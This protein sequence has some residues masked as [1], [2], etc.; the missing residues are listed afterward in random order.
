M[1]EAS[2]SS[3]A[4]LDDL[5]RRMQQKT[6]F[7]ALSDAV[8]RIHNV[9]NS[10][11]ES[12]ASLT[13]EI[14]KDVALTNKLLRMVNSAV[15]AQ[16]GRINTVSRAVSLVGFDAIRNLALSLVLLEH[17]QD[18][19]QAGV[20]KEE[21]LRS[22][23]AGSV[24]S[25]LSASHGDAEEAFLGSMF[26]NLGR[27]L[28]E[29]YLP[30]E[31]ARVRE[32]MAGPAG[33]SE[34]AASTQILGLGYETLGL[35]GARAWGLPPSIQQCMKLPVGTPP[36]H[37]PT[38]TGE[39]LRWTAHVANAVAEVLLHAPQS[40][41]N[42]RL[43]LVAQRHARTLDL[44]ETQVADAV[45]RAQHRL[46]DLAKVME[47]D[48]APS[49]PAARLLAA[50]TASEEVSEETQD[51]MMGVLDGQA[52]P[53]SQALSPSVPDS[54]HGAAPDAATLLAAGIQ[55]V[56]LAMVDEM[57]VSDILRM[58]LETLFRALDFQRVVFALRDPKSDALVGRFGLGLA[59]P[60]GVGQ[61]RVPLGESAQGDVFAAVCR[62][63]ADTLI[64]DSADA[65]LRPR[66]PAWFYPAM[67]AGSFLLLP[68]VV[69]GRPVG[70]IY[71]DKALAR[72]IV[73]DD[74]LLAMVRTLRNQAL[75][76][77]RTPTLAH[78]V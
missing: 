57:H 77:I 41:V 60:G 55:D 47:L 45:V 70:I 49:S 54:L 75:M 59:V 4:T 36:A 64:G 69:K 52:L 48:M 15:Y 29:F 37:V 62:K 6:D 20:L 5:L 65:H 27:L 32:L 1:P 3:A 43:N 39:R 18:R 42:A 25:E 21:Y 23:M 17:L 50:P 74:K 19:A 7:P 76:A 58:V 31:A 12:V 26:Q 40:E 38:D 61:F 10:E 63:G 24:A 13:N 14:L 51:S 67:G 22:L 46:I 53:V 66:F 8:S 16:H 35:G 11:R 2:R 28:A 34:T 9:V 71:A 72:S 68:L 30:Q 44:S 73:M 56:T 78:S 33:L